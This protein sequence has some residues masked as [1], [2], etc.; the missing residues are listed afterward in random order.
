M[1]LHTLMRVQKIHKSLDEVFAFFSDPG[2]LSKITPASLDFRILTPQPIDMKAGALIDYQIKIMG[3]PL[4]WTTLI[5]TYEKPNGFVDVQL[6]GP[7][8]YWHHTHTFHQKE[9][10]VEIVD[11]V[12]YGMPFGFLG[13]LLHSLWVKR[14]LEK[15]FDF[16]H[17]VISDYF[18]EGGTS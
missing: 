1:K 3:I 17:R 2:N 12:V 18:G 11:R 6:K 14:D 7:Y 15:I 8:A 13:D 10:C 5:E 4:R 16:R 9:G